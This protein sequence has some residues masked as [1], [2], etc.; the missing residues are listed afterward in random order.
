M[1][2]CPN[3][4]P[5]LA[6]SLEKTHPPHTKPNSPHKTQGGR[7]DG[8]LTSVAFKL[9]VREGCNCRNIPFIPH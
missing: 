1:G 4:H 7:R 8:I 9:Q 5:R 2:L 6:V 3:P